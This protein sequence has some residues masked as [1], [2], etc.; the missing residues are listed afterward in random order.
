MYLFSI[1]NNFNQS[2]AIICDKNDL[3]NFLT[4]LTENL[5]SEEKLKQKNIVNELNEDEEIIKTKIYYDNER[6]I[7]I[8]IKIFDKKI[9]DIELISVENLKEN[10][11]DFFNEIEKIIED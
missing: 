6:V 9:N 10:N 11:F 4:V 1:K 5:S 2:A 3:Y 8:E 7:S